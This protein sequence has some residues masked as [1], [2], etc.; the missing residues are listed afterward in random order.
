MTDLAAF[1]GVA[2]AVIVTPG[3]D[4]IL[5]IRNT[6]LGGRFSGFLTACGVATGQFIWALSVGTGVAA[7]LV[8][9]AGVFRV[10]KAGGALY[11]V[12]LG[13][14]TLRSAMD[15]SRTL[16]F[17]VRAEDRPR[18]HRTPFREG[19]LSNLGNPKMA[20]FFVGLLP[21]FVP[22]GNPLGAVVLG[23]AF[24]GMTLAWL[25]GYALAVSNATL[26]LSRQRFRRALEATAAVALLVLG[27]T[28]LAE[29]W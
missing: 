13:L 21:Q 5:T 25:S 4:T 19:V 16:P 2:L 17:G 14:T 20:V 3:Q 23:V 9:N 11:L 26:L 22:V 18:T 6:L 12:V 8:A 24:C 7:L 10:L 15:R 1:V 29:S 28:L 27:G